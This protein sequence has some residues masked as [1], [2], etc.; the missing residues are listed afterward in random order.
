MT[1]AKATVLAVLE[2]RHHPEDYVIASNTCNNPQQV[3]PRED[4]EDY[5]KCKTICQQ[6]GHA[7]IEVLKKIHSTDLTDYDLTIIGHDRMCQDC[8]NAVADAGVLVIKFK[9]EHRNDE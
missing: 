9:P 3:C 1:C 2:N 7:E 4:G 6:P 8:M 5:T